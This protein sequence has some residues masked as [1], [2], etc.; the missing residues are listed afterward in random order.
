[1]VQIAGVPWRCQVE[2]ADTRGLLPIGDVARRT[3]FAGMGHRAID[4]AD[5]AGEVE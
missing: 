5:G 2:G 3:D 4:Q 1:M